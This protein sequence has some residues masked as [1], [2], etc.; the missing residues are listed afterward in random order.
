[1]Y[2]KKL[3]PLWAWSCFAFEDVNAMIL[4]SVHGT[5]DVVKQAL[6]KQEISMYIRSSDEVTTT[7]KTKLKVTYKAQNCDVL[8][9]L[10][11]YGRNDLPAC[12]S[13]Y[14]G[15]KYRKS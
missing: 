9:A 15:S 5:R 11:P 3:G 10:H 12:I 7:L 13:V 4:N 2:V 14:W 1:M 6:R 8:G